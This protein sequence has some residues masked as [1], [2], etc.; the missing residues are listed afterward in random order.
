MLP[1]IDL[2]RTPTNPPFVRELN[3]PFPISTP[4]P[5]PEPPPPPFV[6][7][8]TEAEKN[9]PGADITQGAC[10][11]DTPLIPD[12]NAPRDPYFDSRVRNAGR[13]QIVEP[14]TP[15]CWTLPNGAI[16][17]DDT[18]ELV[19]GRFPNG[20]RVTVTGHAFSI[21]PGP[22]KNPDGTFNG[23]GGIF[24]ERAIVTSISGDTV[25]VTFSSQAA[26]SGLK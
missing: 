1:D 22:L 16:V 24:V 4:T 2:P 14:E 6:R 20:A 12:P 17:Y 5:T 21:E 7:E 8:A 9:G 15:Q 26:F 13:T 23:N 3:G 10:G 18:M 19:L 25:I 11:K